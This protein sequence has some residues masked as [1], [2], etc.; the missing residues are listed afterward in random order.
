V[1]WFD[2]TDFLLVCFIFVPLERLAPLRPGQGMFRRA[3]QT[4]LAHLFATGIMIKLGLGVVV[5]LILMGAHQFVPAAIRAAVASQPFVV[6][7]LEL[8]VLADLGFYL[9]HRAFHALPL[10]WKFH[11]VHHSIEELDWLAASRVHPIDQILTKSASFLPVFALGFSPGP[12]FLSAALYRWQSVLIHSNTRIGFGPLR[13]IVAS[14]QFHHWH[15]ANCP[16]AMNKNFAAQLVLF[17]FLFGTLHL[18][19]S[20]MP[21]RYGTNDP[22]PS[23]YLAQLAYPLRR[24][25]RAVLAEGRADDAR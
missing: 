20:R 19:G 22:V 5:G 23:S 2:V 9:M 7:F 11:V 21:E 24:A 14:P 8:L 3:W 15:H 17:D 12:I 18:P 25:R 1:N 10:L 6:Q 13:W 4:D 16:E